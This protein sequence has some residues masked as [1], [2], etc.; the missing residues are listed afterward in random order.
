[1]MT[2]EQAVAVGEIRT[3]CAGQ[4]NCAGQG[5]FTVDVL[6]DID[7]IIFPLQHRIVDV[8]V[9]YGNPGAHVGIQLPKLG[10]ACAFSASSRFIVP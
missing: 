9:R 1:M 7:H 10:E 2:I 6:I 4:K 8:R 5:K 3:V